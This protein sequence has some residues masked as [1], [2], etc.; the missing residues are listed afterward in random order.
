VAR[1]VATLQPRHDLVLVDL[2]GLLG[3]LAETPIRLSSMGRGLHDD[4]AYFLAAAAAGRYAAGLLRPT[5]P[6]G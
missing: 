5:A 4:P 1:A 2:A 6:A 3:L